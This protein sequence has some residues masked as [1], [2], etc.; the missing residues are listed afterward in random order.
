MPSSG[1]QV[2]T[3]TDQFLYVMAPDT[4][5]FESRNADPYRIAAE[6]EVSLSNYYD[7][8]KILFLGARAITQQNRTSL[9][10]ENGLSH[11]LHTWAICEW[12]VGNLDRAQDLFDH[13]LRLSRGKET[14][15]RS[16]IL[17]SIARLKHYKGEQHLAQHYVGLALMDNCMPGGNAKLWAFWAKVADEM[18]DSK[19]KEECLQQAGGNGGVTMQEEDVAYLLN[20]SK[21]PAGNLFPHV[22]VEKCL[23]RRDPWKLKLFGMHTDA[24]H[25]FQ[26]VK[27]PRTED[28]H[29]SES[30]K[31]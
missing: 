5:F 26:S 29:P 4:Q 22:P 3:P 30:V 20:S 8:R 21:A 12:H 19:L 15:L 2:R 27:F 16:F 25:S 1:T 28:R 23:I 14:P 7:A 6:L 31:R 24:L 18:E 10:D 13:A 9:G 11:L 17:Y